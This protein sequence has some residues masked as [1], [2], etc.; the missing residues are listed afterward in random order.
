MDKVLIFI[1]MMMN[2]EQADKLTKRMSEFL[3]DQYFILVYRRSEPKFEVF[4]SKDVTHV[5][6]DELIERIKKTLE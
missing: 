1:G 5:S 4:Y 3:G 2:A 6:L